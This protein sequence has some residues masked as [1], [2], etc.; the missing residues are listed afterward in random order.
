[1][2]AEHE[3]YWLLKQLY[4]EIV[5]PDWFINIRAIHNLRPYM[6]EG[7][8]LKNATRV[9][10]D[11]NIRI[12]DFKKRW[13]DGLLQHLVALNENPETPANIYFGVNPRLTEKANKKDDIAGYVAFYLDCDDNKSYTKEQRAYQ[14][15][16]WKDYGLAPSIVIDSG[17][18][19]HVYWIL[20][21]LESASKQE[22]LKRM[23][24]LSGCKDKGNTHDVT[25]ILRLPG[26]K[27]VKHWYNMDRPQCFIYEP[28]N[29]Q[30]LSSSYTYECDTLSQW[31]PPSERE[32]I[33]NYHARAV[34]MGESVPFNERIRQIAQAAV[35]AEMK[36]KVAGHGIAIA[37]EKQ[38]LEASSDFQKKTS[39][40]KVP[41]TPTLNLVPPL[42]DMT[43]P[44]GKAWMKHYC[45]KGYSGLSD[46]DMEKITALYGDDKDFS[47]SA[48]ESKIIYQ[49]IKWGYTCP[50]IVEF[51]KRIELKLWRQDK[52]DKT[53]NYLQATYD[54]M[55]QSVHATLEHGQHENTA[56]REPHIGIVNHQTFFFTAEGI[57]TP[58]LTGELVLLA[59]YYDEDAPL[60]IDREWFE[61]RA[62]IR[63][64][65]ETH[66]YDMLLPGAAFA[67][68]G[69]FKKHASGEY[70]RI[71]VDKASLLQY[72]LKHLEKEY[73]DVPTRRF[74]SKI[75]YSNGKFVFPKFVC[76]AE[77]PQIK[78]DTLLAESLAKKFEVYKWFDGRFIKPE[79]VAE[80]LEVNW[81]PL[82]GF[83]LPR[84]L[85]SILGT[86][87]SSAIKPIFEEKL[88][89]EDFNLPSVN[90]RGASHSGKTETVKKLCRLTGVI[91]GKNSISTETTPFAMQRT[92]ELATFIPMIIDEFKQSDHNGKSI[93][94][95]RSLVRRIYSG[96]SMMRG[97]ANLD[98][99]NIR[100]HGALIIIGEH[101]LERV[102]DVSEI[103]RVVPISTDEY[104]PAKHISE[105]FEVSETHWEWLAPYFYSFILTQD[106]ETMYEEF[107]ALRLQVIADL[108][109]AFSGEKLRVGH[110]LA[111]IWYG[112]R[113]WDK[114]VQ[115]YGVHDTIE[116]LLVPQTNLV[117]HIKEWSIKSE[118]S[119]VVQQPA[120][121][122]T[123]VSP[124]GETREIVVS[125]PKDSV[126]A[127]NEV[128]KMIRIFNEMKEYKDRIYMDALENNLFLSDIDEKNDILF[129][130]IGAIYALFR[131]YSFRMNTNPTPKDKIFSL[132]KAAFGKKEPW[133]LDYDKVIKR[134]N[135][136]HKVISIRLSAFRAMNLWP[137]E[138]EEQKPTNSSQGAIFSEN[139]R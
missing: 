77:G 135:E 50:A 48:L 56:N 137:K 55:L 60:R 30:E 93:E 44:K 47:A 116:E 31:F 28:I 131:L 65:E 133:I 114:F 10:Y 110:N 113:L 7:K 52:M 102:G 92:L 99:V 127:N 118:Q 126:I 68:I 63:V 119:L 19:F 23:V 96:E 24:L 129:L 89:I 61:I 139:E 120:V 8:M 57:G 16:F 107:K 53:P 21:K 97:R 26:F 132:I 29:W 64:N 13:Y 49:L 84:V 136:T 14:L 117:D 2:N 27:N 115:S 90:V 69:D 112:C 15:Q 18:G 124:S 43:F 74:H 39:T 1:M 134:K 71:L 40:E 42:D 82:L 76:T 100:L 41:F 86:I 106:P 122:E 58:V 45:K 73:P 11:E 5:N 75:V 105:Y 12:A 17:H 9:M 108:S 32:N 130:K 95:V 46:S 83:H 3:S 91:G 35:Q 79:K 103:S 25:R 20:N 51:W 22:A 54:A 6:H 98:V 62:V 94:T 104:E 121:T 85:I 109:H 59:K 81:K 87:A 36:S 70:L 101:N 37:A 72:V 38:R 88:L 125:E 4:R 111:T 66:S 80:F 33:E 34:E 138:I 123:Q 67:T 128:F 78:D